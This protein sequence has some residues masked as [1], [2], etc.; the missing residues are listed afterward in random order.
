MHFLIREASVG[1]VSDIASINNEGFPYLEE[2]PPEFFRW[3]I[4][5]GIGRFL[6]CEVDGEVVGFAHFDAIGDC[7][8]IYRIG[9]REDF[10][11]RG[12][13]SALLHEV[14][15]VLRGLGV[16]KVVAYV[17]KRRGSALSWFLSRGYH[18][19]HRLG[20]VTY[21]WW[22]AGE[23]SPLK[24]V[25]EVT[26]RD[27][28][29]VLSVGGWRKLFWWYPD[30]GKY[31]KYLSTAPGRVYVDKE[32]TCLVHVIS[33]G[34]VSYVE[35]VVHRGVDRRRIVDVVCSAT[36]LAARADDVP[37]CEVPLEP[38]GLLGSVYHGTWVEVP[39]MKYIS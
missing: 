19:D 32:S 39:V 4:L 3:L 34:W 33:Y 29:D 22:V 15:K 27:L 7:G 23:L 16:S 6:V 17:A 20:S 1:D 21:T 12:I 25:C 30:L 35:Y 14:E 2:V 5:H 38:E 18:I 11:G 26:G 9:V 24:E 8:V 13:G 36:E 10:R 31:L 37:Y 28:G